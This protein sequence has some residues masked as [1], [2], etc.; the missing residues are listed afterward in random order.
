MITRRASS[1]YVRLSHLIVLLLSAF[2]RVRIP[3]TKQRRREEGKM[4]R[5]IG[6]EGIMRENSNKA[7]FICF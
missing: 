5:R 7:N 2:P 3:E 6:E 4:E 1:R